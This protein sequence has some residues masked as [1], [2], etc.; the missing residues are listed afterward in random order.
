[1]P[2]VGLATGDLK[3]LEYDLAESW[4]IEANRFPSLSEED[5]LA[6]LRLA[7]GG[8]VTARNKVVKA[9]LKNI[10]SIIKKISFGRFRGNIFTK[11]HSTYLDAIQVGNITLIEA[12]YSYP[13]IGDFM[14][15]LTICIKQALEKELP[16]LRQTIGFSKRVNFLLGIKEE[17]E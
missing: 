11:K 15:H 8:D 4:R 1:M 9:N 17:E 5:Q 6:L 2:P 16:K 10:P 12:I 7:K 3:Q 13:G 14:K